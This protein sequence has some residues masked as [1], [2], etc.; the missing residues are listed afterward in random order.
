MRFYRHP[1]MLSRSFLILQIDA[2]EE[3]SDRMVAKFLLIVS[4]N[5]KSL[6]KA[7]ATLSDTFSRSTSLLTGLPFE[8]I[9]VCRKR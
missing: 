7:F 4:V 5:Y 1:R 9:S 2:I 8:L 3:G 6:V